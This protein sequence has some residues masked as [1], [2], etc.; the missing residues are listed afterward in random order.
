MLLRLALVIFVPINLIM[1][2]RIVHPE[3]GMPA[4]HELRNRVVELR[5]KIEELHAVNRELSAEIRALRHDDSYVR[6]LIRRELLYAEDG[7][8]MY[9]FK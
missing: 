6:R 9:I 3:T 7:E 8:I 4:Y 2:Y 1:A 5:H